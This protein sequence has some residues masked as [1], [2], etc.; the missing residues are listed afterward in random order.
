MTTVKKFEAGDNT[1]EVKMYTAEGRIDSNGGA[2]PWMIGR[3]TTEKKYGLFING[4]DVCGV[5]FFDNDAELVEIGKTFGYD[6]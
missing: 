4:E 6:N 1:Y 2:A 3:K 5:A